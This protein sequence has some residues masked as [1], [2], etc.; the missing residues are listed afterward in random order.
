MEKVSIDWAVR[1]SF[2]DARPSSVQSPDSGGTGRSMVV[3]SGV[4]AMSWLF[5]VWVDF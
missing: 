5:Q 3:P 4:I 1:P 2:V